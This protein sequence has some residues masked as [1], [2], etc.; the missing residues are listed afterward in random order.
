MFTANLRV[1]SLESLPGARNKTTTAAPTPA[2]S[3]NMFRTISSVP[4]FRTYQ[5]PQPSTGTQM[6]D[7]RVRRSRSASRR[8]YSADDVIP[9]AP[10][11]PLPAHPM[12]SQRNLGNNADAFSLQQRSKSTNVLGRSRSFSSSS[13]QQR[14]PLNVSSLNVSSGRH[15]VNG[16]ASWVPQSPTVSCNSSRKVS[17]YS[18]SSHAHIMRQQS[19]QDMTAAM[20]S[21]TQ[22][23]QSATPLYVPPIAA[24]SVNTC[25]TS[26]VMDMLTL[27]PNL[28]VPKLDYE[29]SPY[30]PHDYMS[31][32]NLD[33]V[34]VSVANM[35]RCTA[36]ADSPTSSDT[37]INT[38]VEEQ[39]QTTAAIRF[40]V[41]RHTTARMKSVMM[42][43]SSS[44]SQ[45]VVLV[46]MNGLLILYPFKATSS[47]VQKLPRL[48]DGPITHSCIKKR[49]N[50]QEISTF[51]AN[52][53]G[54]S[55]IALMQL[56]D[57]AV[58]VVAGK[59]STLK[60]TGVAV[61]R[62]LFGRDSRKEEV[63]M[64]EME[65]AEA[66]DKWRVCIEALV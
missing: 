27:S 31:N 44:I 45:E 34:A 48:Y 52:T 2:T 37:T 33:P 58:G 5:T 14:L 42:G 53:L 24:L 41:V 18:G 38:P 47:G 9:P 61:R 19:S 16:P 66:L 20:Y 13:D 46:A 22:H 25:P 1:P 64:F 51:V 35:S 32:F 10:L 28:R 15:V 57:A 3:T 43:G 11:E 26:R 50:E 8:P 29:L 12:T 62:T 59:K 56:E 65:G 54:Q 60:V 17:Q 39:Q 40:G 55:P 49:E 63:W 7:S 30:T 36:A 6:S 21:N 23:K 4:S